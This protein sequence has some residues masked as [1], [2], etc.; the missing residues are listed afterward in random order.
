MLSLANQARIFFHERIKENAS[1]IGCTNFSLGKIRTSLTLAILKFAVL[2]TV[3]E[4]EQAAKHHK[5][6]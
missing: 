5:Y 6:E 3:E 2:F 1:Y 4:I